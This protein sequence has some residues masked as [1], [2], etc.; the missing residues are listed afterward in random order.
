MEEVTLK[1]KCGIG[2]EISLPDSP[3]LILVK[4]SRGFIACGYLDIDAANKVG[5]AAATIKGVN[6]VKELLDG[7][8]VEA[9]NKA[10]KAGIKPGMKGR[11]ALE[12]IL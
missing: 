9:T 7:A 11:D 4:G 2:I 5:A 8:I 10:L 12:K 6:S 1:G 3:P